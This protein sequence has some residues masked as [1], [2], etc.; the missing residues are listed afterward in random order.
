METIIPQQKVD[1]NILNE[2][3]L[4]GQTSNQHSP[5][6]F[7]LNNKRDFRIKKFLRIDQFKKGYF[8]LAFSFNNY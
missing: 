3:Y 6:Y 5:G 4:L 1:E 8:S 2:P 7:I